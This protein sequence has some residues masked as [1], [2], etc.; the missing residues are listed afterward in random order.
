M[1]E[2][3]GRLMIV[4]TPIGNLKDISLRAIETLREAD[5]IAAEDTRHSGKLLKT[6]DIDTKMVSLHKFNE[7]QKRAYLLNLMQQGSTVALISDAGTPGIC[8]PGEDLIK[9]CIEEGID[10]VAIPGA[11]AMPT[12]L[13]LSGF[14]TAPF[15]F[16]G[17]LPK[18]KSEK[19]AL[20]QQISTGTHTAVFYESPH[21]LLDSLA[22]IERL[23]PLRRLCLC[24][25]LTKL[26]EEIVRGTAAEIIAHYENKPL[27]GEIV[28]VLQGAPQMQEQITLPQAKELVLQKVH[29]GMA[30]NE[31]I[32]EVC[33]QYA[34]ERKAL[35]NLL[36]KE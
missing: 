16:Y 6:Y 9:A 33:R 4:S 26:H 12:A 19:L 18:K 25:E 21:R 14:S 35:Y 27:K 1:S 8:D 7:T 23:M 17:F 29:R 15:S 2:K 22:L 5:Y 3:T 34:L 24:R 32:K 20:L 31:A 10:L 28:L 11:S 30:K 13:V 36:T